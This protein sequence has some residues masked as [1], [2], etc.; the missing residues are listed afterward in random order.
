MIKSYIGSVFLNASGAPFDA[1]GYLNKSSKSVGE[2]CVAQQSKSIITSKVII[3]KNKSSESAGEI[4][5]AQQ[6]K[7]TQTSMVTV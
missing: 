6:S 3:N 2:I 5:V 7:S 1:F 4:C